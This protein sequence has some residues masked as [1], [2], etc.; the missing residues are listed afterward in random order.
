VPSLTNLLIVAA[1]AFDAPLA[2]GLLAGSR[3]GQLTIAG[4]SIADALTTVLLSLFFSGESS[5]LGARWVLLVGFV[6]MVASVGIAIVGAQRSMRLTDALIR[7][8]DT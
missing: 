1:I 3:F 6:L 5:G 2:L 4:A 8:Q 7:L